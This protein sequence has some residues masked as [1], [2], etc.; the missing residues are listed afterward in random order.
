MPSLHALLRRQRADVARPGSA[1][2][3]AV[4]S[5]RSAFSN[6]LID[7]SVRALAGAVG[8]QQ[9]DHAALGHR[10]STRP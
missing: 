8:A 2:R 1:I 7:F 5:P 6:P 10:R 4:T 9:R 3:R